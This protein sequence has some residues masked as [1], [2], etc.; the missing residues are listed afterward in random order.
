MRWSAGAHDRRAR[1]LR[2]VGALGAVAWLTGPGAAGAEFL[3]NT[4]LPLLVAAQLLGRA[5]HAVA[6]DR[7]VLGLTGCATLVAVT[8]AH[9]PLPDAT[10][11]AVGVAVV[12][13]IA[14]WAVAT[15][16]ARA[17]TA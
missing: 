14:F 15:R 13:V 1:L 3:M 11:D 2:W 10:L 8:V 12:T 5:R 16:T 6:T 17:V 4:A 9:A 7:W